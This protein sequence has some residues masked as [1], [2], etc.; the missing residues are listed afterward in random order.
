[1]E[2]DFFNPLREKERDYKEKLR[3]YLS[4]NRPIYETISGRKFDFEF[5]EGTAFNQETKKVI[6]GVNQLEKLNIDIDKQGHLIDF[7]V[8]HEL[9]H[10]TELYDDPAGYTELL[11]ELSKQKNGRAVFRLYNALQDIYVN[12]LTRDNAAVYAGKVGVERSRFSDEVKEFYR[13]SLF[14]R[15][16]VQQKIA[17]DDYP[18]EQQFAD[19]LLNEGMG[20]GDDFYELFDERVK[21]VIDEGVLG[22]TYG[23]L[24]DTFL[25]PVIN[26]R[27]G[28]RMGTISERREIIDKYILPKFLELLKESK[29]RQKDEREE[30]K[31]D[32]TKMDG[33]EGIEEKSEQSVDTTEDE[34]MKTW[35]KASEDAMDKKKEREKTPEEKA[36]DVAKEQL[37]RIAEERG[38]S[39]GEFNDFYQRLSR[40]ENISVA[41]SKILARISRVGVR[42]SSEDIGYFKTGKKL[43]VK[44][45]VN[46]MGVILTRPNEAEVM[47]KKINTLEE[48]V[49]PKEFVLSLAIDES[50]SMS[51][52]KIEMVKDLV[53]AIANAFAKFNLQ[54]EIDFGKD[55]PIAQLNIVGYDDKVYPILISSGELKIGDIMAVYKEIEA[56][57][58]TNDEAAIS[59]L[60]KK[61]IPPETD[62]THNGERID[63]LIE[64][65]DGDSLE[66]TRLVL[67]DLRERGV[68]ANGILIGAQGQNGKFS[69][70]FPD[71][72]M[73]DGVDKLPQAVEN[74]LKEVL[75][76]KIRE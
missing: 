14:N 4:R 32:T 67:A 64:V 31:T 35:R 47:L 16:S 26:R 40:M 70:N 43:D 18:L 74:I 50:G 66:T 17:S 49:L 69:N 75:Q 22:F 36:K 7:L 37:E 9:G 12:N 60:Q 30:Q 42:E 23:D 15:E 41:I 73:I 57:G 52:D 44:Q 53:I 56:K 59:Y 10:F 72:V 55:R 2:R 51:G 54:G 20:V 39:D 38:L 34:E 58:N 29:E 24:I 76:E 6:I 62:T 25:R 5:G 33:D 28:E 8:F 21:K 13:E 1:M 61:V 65:T 48:E 11:D 45:V 3:D 27:R 46:R 19:Y 71:G 68:I 63:I